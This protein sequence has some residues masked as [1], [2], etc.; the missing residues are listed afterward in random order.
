MRSHSSLQFSITDIALQAIK[1]F[2]SHELFQIIPTDPNVAAL[3]RR[4]WTDT[5]TVCDQLL[6]PPLE[7]AF[8]QALI[9][10][11]DADGLVRVAMDDD[12]RPYFYIPSEKLAYEMVTNS[13]DMPKHFGRFEGPD[14]VPPS[15]RTR[16]RLK[17]VENDRGK[18]EEWLV[19]NEV[20]GWTYIVFEN[21]SGPSE[22]RRQCCEYPTPK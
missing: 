6:R 20:N 9:N 17:D 19:E 8:H 2:R 3:H 10:A 15:S 12:A 22:E 18:Y 14:D 1:S 13:D 11:R 4:Y 7:R 5:A 16:A 21:G